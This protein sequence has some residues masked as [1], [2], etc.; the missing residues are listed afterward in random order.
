MT[1]KPVSWRARLLLLLG[2][3][4]ASLGVAELGLRLT[5]FDLNPSP[6]FRYHSR[7]GWTLDAAT[8]CRD[9]D[10]IDGVAADGFRHPDRGEAASPEGTAAAPARAKAP[11][12]RRLAILGDSYALG[13]A[14][15]RHQT[16]AGL[17]ST[18][19]RD[20]GEDWEVLNYGV[21]GW[22]TAQ[23]LL[24]LEHQVLALEPDIVVLQVLPFNDLCNNNLRQ[25][26]TCGRQDFHRPYL[27][28]RGDGRL[29]RS[30][31]NPRR[32]SLRRASRLFGLVENQWLRGP[33]ARLGV[34]DPQLGDGRRRR[35]LEEVW[36]AGSGLEFQSNLY[37]LIPEARQPKA[38]REGWRVTE[39]IFERMAE[40][41]AERDIPFYA[42]VV[43]FPGTFETVWLDRKG[44][45]GDWPQARD[46]VELVPDYGT[47]RVERELRS[48]G[49]EVI[50][51][52]DEILAGELAPRDY[53]YPPNRVRDRHFNSQGHRAVAS[54]LLESLR[55]AELTT[56]APPSAVP[57]KVDLLSPEAHPL[58]ARRLW[59]LWRRA[60]HYGGAPD[61]RVVFEADGERP[62]KLEFDLES[63]RPE[64]PVRLVFNDEKV[65]AGRYLAVGDRLQQ[66][67]EL[68][69]RPGRNE[70]I[71]RL[72][73]RLPE[74]E[75]WTVRF[76]RLQLALE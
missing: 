32:A 25:I 40:L 19:L 58:A 52:R 36:A 35:S 46:G 1:R 60:E 27:V 7:Y 39:A 15:P 68:E 51:L 18:W 8:R 14:Y 30:W 72:G 47:R 21:S 23:Q 17:L 42:V 41:L 73:R 38:V 67:L 28:H 75:L 71:F 10:C 9:D 43:P 11:G 49:A 45:A 59:N 55:R 56:A 57:W 50:A 2:S 76:R 16:F 63:L 29:G 62:L 26:Y 69:T 33:E 6:H 61:M 65:M 20:S 13:A 4:A 5:A 34:F 31:A 44:A 12:S 66:V 22:G 54:L 37:S 53:Y 48:L 3:L 24:V 74:G 64:L 70:L